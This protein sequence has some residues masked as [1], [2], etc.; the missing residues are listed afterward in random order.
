[1]SVILNGL[2]G[3]VC[4]MDDILIWGQDQQ[5][6]NARLHI[7]LDK[8]QEAGITL[9]MEKCELSKKEVKFLGHILSAEGVQP[10]PD[11]IRAVKAMKEPSNFR[12]VHSFLGMVNQLGKFIPRLAEKDK[13]LRDLLSKKNQFV[14][15][16]KLTPTRSE[17]I[18]VHL[19]SVFS[20]HTIPEIF[21]SDNGPQFSSQQF[22][23][24]AAAYGFR[25]ITSSPSL[26]FL[27][28]TI[29]AL[30]YF[31]IAFANMSLIVVICMNRS[32]HEPMYMFLCSLFVNELYGSTGLFPFLLVQILSDVH[33]ISAA[34]CFLQVFCVHT[35]GSIELSNLAVMSYDRYL[36]IC[37]P[38]EYNKLMTLNYAAVLITVIWLY[39]FLRFLIPFLLS[40]TLTLCSNMIEKL[41][42]LNYQIVKLACSDTTLNNIYGLVDTAAVIA[43]HLF[44]ILYSYTKILEVCFHG[45]KQMKLKALSTCTPH[46][47]SLI[48]FSLGCSFEVFQTRF[49]MSSVPSILRIILFLYFYIMQPLLNPI[50]FGMQM[51]KIKE[52]VRLLFCGKRPS[53]R[54]KI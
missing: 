35:F 1:M 33:T 23:D 18:I 13:P 8:L 2:P 29:T 38:L 45:S 11:K 6:H 42:C 25:H 54:G 28:F 48:N 46:L 50:M 39:N 31:V 44:P 5:E 40:V 4:H 14:E 15:I 30:L 37:R 10:D 53:R 41:Y 49:D 26:K 43:L 47:V 12:E 24:F 32:L 17:N 9:N 19:K 7:V 3:V 20:R 52:K 51:S 27:C 21:Y 22:K 36:A 34:L 16:A